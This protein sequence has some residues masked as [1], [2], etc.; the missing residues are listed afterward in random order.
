MTYYTWQPTHLTVRDREFTIATK[1]GLPDTLLA[2]RLLADAVD[3]EPGARVIDLRCGTGLVGAALLARGA[4]VK[5]YDDNG[6]AVEAA[7]RT[8]QANGLHSVIPAGTWRESSDPIDVD[9]RRKHATRGMTASSTRDAC[10][11]AIINAPKG[12]EVGRRLIRSAIRA[13]KVGGRLYIGGA[14][15]GGVKSLIDDARDLIGSMNVIKIKA[16]HRVAVGVRGESIDLSDD[17]EFT[18]HTVAVRDQTWRYTACPG[19]FAWDRLDDGS[20]ALIETMQLNRA[21]SVLDLGCGSGLI[22]L[23]AATLAD[24]V[25][26]VDASALAIE[27]THRTYEINRVLNTEVLISDCGSAVFDRTFDAVV[28][29]PP[30]HQGVGTD[31]AVARQFV[32]DAAR[33]LRSGGTLWLVANRFL[34]Y[35]R[36]LADRF[37]HVRVAY[38]DNRFRVLAAIKG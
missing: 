30:F 3:V 12:R 36:E 9:A 11:V 25:V 32:I 28:T 18:E 27:A 17:P 20:R 37:A 22:G 13:L 19:V 29:N 10:D 26:S 33:V 35:E 38:E 5:L 23:V 16:A 34:R 1:P 8:L 21:D 6:V 24:R 15:R 14:N 4:E 31:Y 2:E 7:R